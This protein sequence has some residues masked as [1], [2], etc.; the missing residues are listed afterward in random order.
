[1]E[2]REAFWNDHPKFEKKYI[3]K[4][5]LNGRYYFARALQNDYD[6]DIRAAFVEYIDNLRKSG[7]ITENL[8][9]KATLK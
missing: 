9:N 7:V 1:M 2:I 4:Q 5:A 6:T 3:Y 8:A